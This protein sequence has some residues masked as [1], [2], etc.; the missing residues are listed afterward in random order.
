MTF[1]AAPTR[2]RIIVASARR[3]ACGLLHALLILSYRLF[4]F[5]SPSSVRAN[6]ECP[7]TPTEQVRGEVRRAVLLANRPQNLVGELRKWFG[8]GSERTPQGG[9]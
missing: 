7:G 6:P 4:I 1:S 8:S 9:S 3:R 2:A 5:S